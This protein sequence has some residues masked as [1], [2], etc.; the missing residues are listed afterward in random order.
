MAKDFKKISPVQAMIMQQAEA[1]A[2]KKTTPQAAREKE[3][4]EGYK[5]N[6]DL[7]E[8]KTRRVQLV[9]QPSV[10]NGLKALADKEGI[11]FNDYVHRMAEE[12]IKKNEK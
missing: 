12:Q 6:Y 5:V 10:Y 4:P 7:I 8:K 2:P 1:E 9:F 3:I 11:S